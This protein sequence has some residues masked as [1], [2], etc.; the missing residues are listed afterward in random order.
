MSLEMSWNLGRG[1]GPE[2]RDRSGLRGGSLGT[3]PVQLQAW[4][5]TTF[6]DTWLDV[7][8]AVPHQEEDGAEGPES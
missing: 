3:L 2:T 1:R 8:P 4:M 7:R 6:P 5:V